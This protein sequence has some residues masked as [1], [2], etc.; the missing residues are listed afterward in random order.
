MN[1]NEYFF[2][3]NLILLGFVTVFFTIVR[4]NEEIY[5]DPSDRHKEFKKTLKQ[6]TD[7]FKKI[8]LIATATSLTCIFM[9]FYHITLKS[10]G[11]ESIFLTVLSSFG[12]DLYYLV[13]YFF[14]F[15]MLL[16]YVLIQ[17]KKISLRDL[18]LIVIIFWISLFPFSYFKLEGMLILLIALI[19]MAIITA[20]LS[21]PK[22]RKSIS[23][24]FLKVNK[25]RDD[26]KIL[27]IIIGVFFFIE[28]SPYKMML[29]T[30]AATFFAII[31]FFEAA[32]STDRSPKKKIKESKKKL[33]EDAKKMRQKLAKELKSK[34]KLKKIPKK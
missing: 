19:S 22:L 6:K 8:F 9:F 25:F 20:Y 10:L 31:S 12:L 17:S 34:K 26:S 27:I 15:L 16:L 13:V 4:K 3:Y 33:K 5:E 1:I 23:D 2:F 32:R 30:A 29:L 11:M 24:E 14:V 18:T 28:S 21:L 7:S